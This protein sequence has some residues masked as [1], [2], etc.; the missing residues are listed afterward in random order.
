MNYT[1]TQLN[2]AFQ[3]LPGTLQDFIMS[4]EVAESV[5][6]IA[7][8]YGID[9]SI[10]DAF[11]QNIF[12]LLVGVSSITEFTQ[13]LTSLYKVSPEDANSV[14]LDVGNVIL[15]PAHTLLEG[16]AKKTEPTPTS[17]QAM[18]AQKIQ[19]TYSTPSAPQT[20]KSAPS[21]LLSQVQKPISTPSQ[22]TTAPKP[23]FTA[24]DVAQAVKNITPLKQVTTA[25]TRPVTPAAP[26]IM[27]TRLSA[28]TSMPKQD[29]KIPEN[30]PQA[31]HNAELPSG[32]PRNEL[33][34]KDPYREVIE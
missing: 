12:A 9:D 23:Q 2:D 34:N 29:V 13:N 24:Q 22:M 3:K 16:E 19:M 4:D 8:K 31:P 25:Y 32:S 33:L 10:F 30:L 14:V 18:N 17:I 26:S 7:G 27:N 21:I 11:S 6:A 1:Q 5:D 28:T 15:A 20:Q